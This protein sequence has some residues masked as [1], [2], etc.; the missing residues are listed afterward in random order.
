MR[1]TL[2]AVAALSWAVSAWASEPTPVP[3]TRTELKRLLEESKRS[4]PRLKAPAPT[5]V[6]GAVAQESLTAAL[7]TFS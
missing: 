1:S 5:P 3:L 7:P 4:I 6:Q 2:L